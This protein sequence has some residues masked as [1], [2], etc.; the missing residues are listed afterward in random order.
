MKTTQVL[1]YCSTQAMALLGNPH[2]AL[3]KVQQLSFV[4]CVLSG[5][6]L[7][8][9]KRLVKKSFVFSPE[10]YKAT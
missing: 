2:S 9:T 3:G 6:R 8:L 1:L 7:K 5:A 10:H 4:L